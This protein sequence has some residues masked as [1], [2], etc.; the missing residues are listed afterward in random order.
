[1]TRRQQ[2]SFE[3]PS[4]PPSSAFR[5]T[6]NGDRNNLGVNGVASFSST[7]SSSPSSGPSW[8]IVVLLMVFVVANLVFAVVF[9]TPLIPG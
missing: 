7:K 4:P 9:M 1:M 8:R 5:H 2:Q 6:D 3:A